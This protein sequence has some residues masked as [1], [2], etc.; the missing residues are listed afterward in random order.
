MFLTAI[1]AVVFR[2]EGSHADHRIQGLEV[3][4]F[5]GLVGPVGASS[6]AEIAWQHMVANWRSWNGNCMPH[7][8]SPGRS[9]GSYG[10]SCYRRCILRGSHLANILLAIS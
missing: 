4:H 3:V 2:Q 7:R 6:V 10:H 1:A 5:P 8:R 9:A